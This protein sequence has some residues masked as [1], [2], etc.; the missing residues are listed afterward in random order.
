[1]VALASKEF[2]EDED[3]AGAEEAAAEQEVEERITGSGDGEHKIEIHREV[4]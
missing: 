4:D 2:G 3:D 1:V